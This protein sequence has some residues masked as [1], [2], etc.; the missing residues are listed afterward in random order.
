MIIMYKHLLCAMYSSKI[1]AR[2]RYK[3]KICVS[4]FISITIKYIDVTL[5][6]NKH[7]KLQ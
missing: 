2:I 3:R 6:Q 7:A 5:K 1:L 4:K